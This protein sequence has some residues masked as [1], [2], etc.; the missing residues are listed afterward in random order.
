MQIEDYEFNGRTYPCRIIQDNEGTELIVGSASFL[1]ALLPGEFGD[2]N[3]GFASKEAENIDEE[4]FFYTDDED[5]LL[6]DRQ[7]I[8]KLK[9]TIPECFE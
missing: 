8:E 4:I 2:K 6:D 3:D 9:L 1:K 7:L 5:L